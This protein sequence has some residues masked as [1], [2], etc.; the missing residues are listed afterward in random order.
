MLHPRKSLKDHEAIRAL[1]MEQFA[2]MRWQP[3]TRIEWT[4]FTEAFLSGAR[5]IPAQRPPS[6]ISPEAFVSRMTG[7]RDSGVLSA[8]HETDNGIGVFVIGNIAVAIAGCEMLENA[9]D[10]TWDVSVFLLIRSGDTWKIASQAWDRLPEALET[11]DIQAGMKF[12]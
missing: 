1:I 7:L 2:C 4:G 9:T 10:R 11:A 6:P 3:G 5:L 8:F 12:Y